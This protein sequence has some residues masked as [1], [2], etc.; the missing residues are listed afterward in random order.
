MWVSAHSIV[1]RKESVKADFFVLKPFY[2]KILD[3]LC[4]VAYTFRVNPVASE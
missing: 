1:S 4:M 3:R 2:E